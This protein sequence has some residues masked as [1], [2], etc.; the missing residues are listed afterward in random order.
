MGKAMPIMFACNDYRNGS[1]QGWFD[2]IIIE[3]YEATIDCPRTVI[4]Y[5]DSNHVRIGRMV[6]EHRGWSEWVGNW[7]WDQL[8]ILDYKRLLRMLRSKGAT[9][10]CAHTPLFR[11]FNGPPN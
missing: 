3:K 8:Y 1:G 6:F 9:C 10:E 5:I 2:Q 11:W 4:K 7:C